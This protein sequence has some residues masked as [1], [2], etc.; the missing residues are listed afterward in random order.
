MSQD[1]VLRAYV[2]FYNERRPH[3]GLD[4]RCPVPL[5]PLSGWGPIVRRDVLGGLI[6]DYE[7]LAA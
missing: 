1:R 7:R 3:Q 4:Q 5:D 6:H 2:A